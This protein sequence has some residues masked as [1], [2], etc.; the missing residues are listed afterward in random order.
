MVLY[1]IDA[2]IRR[3]AAAHG[4]VYSSWVDDL[5][6]SGQQARQLIPVAITTLKRAG[7]KISRSKL[8]V[9]GSR[10]QRV[11]NGVIVGE[12]PSISKQNRDRIR[13]A[14]HRLRVGDI[15][16]DHDAQRPPH[17]LSPNL[18]GV[19]QEPEQLSEFSSFLMNLLAQ[20]YAFNELHG[21]EVRPVALTNLS[22]GRNVRM[23]ERGGRCCFLFE[24]P[25][26]ILVRREISRKNL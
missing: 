26:P 24:A 20:G 12:K 22:D 15:R 7:F 17:E 13:A 5:P 1:S 16:K 23:I 2:P 11:V 4:V 21:D 9:R 3:A 25:H 6:F 10:K 19:L 8:K 18:G 14:L